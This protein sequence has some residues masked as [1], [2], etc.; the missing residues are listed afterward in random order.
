MFSPIRTAISPPAFVIT[1][2]KK[3]HD[4]LPYKTIRVSKNYDNFIAMPKGYQ[5]Y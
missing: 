4:L 1:Q 3:D 5:K 2:E